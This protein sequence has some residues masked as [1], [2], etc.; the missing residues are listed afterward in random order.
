LDGILMAG[1]FESEESRFLMRFLKPGM[2]VLDVGAHHGYYTL[3]SSKAVG[4]EGTVIAFEPSPRERTRLREHTQLNRC[5]NVSI[6][7][8]ALGI[9]NQEVDFF[10]VQGAEDY[11]N[12]LRPPVV[13]AATTRITTAVTTL[14]DFLSREDRRRVDFIKLDVEGAELGVLRGAPRLLATKPR[15][16][17]L[18]EVYDIRTAAWGYAACE[19]VSLLGGMGYRWYRLLKGG[20]PEPISADL[21][22]YD[23]NLLAVPIERDR[24]LADLQAGSGA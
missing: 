5:A 14:D 12:S 6:E 4:P 24:E 3:L 16:V 2:M 1:S 21:L 9:C 19:I 7:P 8:M 11:C 23:M 13:D 18:V 20:V 15:P 17:L 10:L 22:S